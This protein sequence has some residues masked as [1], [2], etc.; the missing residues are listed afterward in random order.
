M[1]KA[2]LT[3]QTTSNLL[4]G[5]ADDFDRIAA[6]ARGLSKGLDHDVGIGTLARATTQYNDIH[7]NLPPSCRRRA[8]Y[9]LF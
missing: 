9:F 2:V 7:R 1:G 4:A 6:L 8:A 3:S 5:N